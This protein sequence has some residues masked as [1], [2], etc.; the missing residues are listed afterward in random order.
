MV[1]RTEQ[2]T[3]EILNQNL[4][5][6]P[7]LVEGCN[8]LNQ[9]TLTPSTSLGMTAQCDNRF[10]LF[11]N[12]NN[13]LLSIFL[14]SSLLFLMS[15]AN[16]LP[17]GGGEL[18]TVPPEIIFS[19]PENGTTNFKDDYIKFEFSEYVDKRSFKDA[20]F[21]SPAIDEQLEISWSGT[22]VEIGFPTGLKDSLTYVVTIGTDVV[23][24]NNKNRMSNSYSFSFATG[25][26]I[27]K[28]SIDGSVYGKDAEGTLIFAYKYSDDTTKYLSNKPDYLSQI[29]KD[30]TYKLNGL[31][32]S[33]YLVFAVKDEF[34]DLLYQADKDLIGIP[35]KEISLTKTD[36]SYSGLNFILMKVDTVKPRILGTVMTDMNHLVITLSEECDSS[37]YLA[38]NFKVID[39]TSNQIY[40]VDYLYHSISKNE[41]FILI[42][43]NQLNSENNYYLL[44]KELRDL[45]GNI[46]EN[47]LSGFVISDKPDTTALNLVRTD[48]NRNGSIDFKNS[49]ILLSFDDAIDNKEINNAIQFTDT[50]KNKINF[51]VVFVDDATLSIKPE[52]DLKPEKNY[53]IK[54]DL[55]Y[56]PD[57]AGNKVDSIYILKFQTITGVEFTGIS[58]KVTSTKS[59]VV[60]VLEDSKDAKKY[61]TAVPDK[62]MTYSFERMDAGTYSL[63][64]YSDTD[65]SKTFD[66]G[67][68][69]PFRYSEEFYVVPDT[70]KLLPRWGVTD[71]NIVFE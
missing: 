22:S 71:F 49:E 66:K 2:I 69:E 20:V 4:S 5:C 35:S 62:T 41:E 42:Y 23:D 31:V 17:P 50:S 29:G 6:H 53:E 64:I 58:G 15:C 18:D 9:V 34:R 8:I 19:Y 56:F 40:P 70:I 55:K 1:K 51:N 39:S 28:R 45:E 43:K 25:D 54:I 63:W 30:G 65:S 11:S 44:A 59:N 3:T 48:P 27:D 47:E 60:V 24:V 26:K 38:D 33:V 68:P 37:T 13:I 57:A 14:L 12:L 46:F 7:E 10:L 32:E 61:F 21:I 16:Q 67:Y 52:I 36:S